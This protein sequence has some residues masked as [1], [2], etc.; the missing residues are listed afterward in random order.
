MSFIGR[1]II[2][3]FLLCMV[4]IGGGFMSFISGSIDN[5]KLSLCSQNSEEAVGYLH[6]AIAVAEEDGTIDASESKQLWD[7]FVFTESNSY[8]S[9]SANMEPNVEAAFHSLFGYKARAFFSYKPPQ[10]LKEA[11]DR[12]AR[13]YSTDPREQ[14]IYTLP[15][16]EYTDRLENLRRL[17]GEDGLDAYVVSEELSIYYLTGIRFRP[18]ERPFYLVMFADSRFKPKL[19]IPRL[20]KKHF[21]SSMNA[22]GL[23][24]VEVIEYREHVSN[25]GTRWQDKLSELFDGIDHLGLEGRMPAESRDVIEES[26]S[27]VYEKSVKTYRLVEELRMIKSP[28]EIEILEKSAVCARRMIDA[29]LDTAFLGATIAHTF[30]PAGDI[31]N[32]CMFGATYQAGQRP[33][34]L[35][36]HTKLTGAVWPASMSVDPHYIPYLDDRIGQ[37]ASVAFAFAPLNGYWTEL[38]RTF[39]VTKPTEEE[40][41]YYGIMMEARQVA[42][43]MLKP[44]V[45]LSDIS[46]ASDSVLKKHGVMHLWLHR[47]GHGIGLEHHEDP[48]IVEGDKRILR[49]GM[50]VTIEPGIYVE[51]IGAFRHSDTYLITD[52]GSENLTPFA[53]DIDSMTVTGFKPWKRIMDSLIRSAL[54]MDSLNIQVK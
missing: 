37:G 40:M 53:D 30:K 25:P 29:L 17:I 4:K 32:R 44:G 54:H 2:S 43:E 20:E 21:E 34:L 36:E 51:G 33:D 35:P 49:P 3:G 47:T 45:R 10:T 11:Y 28:Y 14:N 6:E 15:A 24:G 5:F 42:R 27:G 18:L 46:D 52:D 31:Q 19:L 8:Y 41:K 39:F 38:E 9:L 1:K 26:I 50:V 16:H 12:V 7:A 22:I 48:F 13:K 23:E